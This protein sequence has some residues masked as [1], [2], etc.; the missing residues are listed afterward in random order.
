ML[1]LKTGERRAGPLSSAA[2]GPSGG[3]QARLGYSFALVVHQVQPP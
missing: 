2:G 1:A 3:I